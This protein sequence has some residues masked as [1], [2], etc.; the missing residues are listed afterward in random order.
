M[1]IM[2]PKAWSTA[3][4]VAC[5]APAW[6]A[7]VADQAMSRF[8]M[9]CDRAGKA[10]AVY[11]CALD[12]ALA[13]GVV[14]TSVASACRDDLGAARGADANRQLW[15][16]ARLRQFGPKMPAQ[17]WHD[18]ATRDCDHRA[19]RAGHRYERR[20]NECIA[21]AIIE[22]QRVP[23]LVVQDCRGRAGSD[24]NSGHRLLNCLV[25]SMLPP[26]PEAR[27]M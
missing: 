1:G 14:S 10:D 2:N 19:R 24:R 13:E 27:R 8:V 15:F 6:P 16:C 11:G 20:R 3:W 12:Q 25:E 5:A 17:E 4:L 22:Q 9:P 21:D 18:A 23:E 26:K 7:G